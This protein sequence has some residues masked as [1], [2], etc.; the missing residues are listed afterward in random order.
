MR[1]SLRRLGVRVVT[2]QGMSPASRSAET[3]APEGGS[4]SR[5]GGWLFRDR[6]SSDCDDG[7]Q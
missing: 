5:S 7:E 6:A 3:P 4:K 1:I 2:A